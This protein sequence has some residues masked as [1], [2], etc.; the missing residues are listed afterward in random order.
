M[1]LIKKWYYPPNESVLKNAERLETLIKLVNQEKEANGSYEENIITGYS[2]GA[3]CVRLALQKMEKN[4][5]ENNADHHHSK[6]FVSFDGEHG[7]ANVP[8]GLQHLVEHLD[9]YGVFTTNDLLYLLGGLPGAA[10]GA[11]EYYKRTLNAYALHYILNAPLSRELLYYFYTETGTSMAYNLGQGAHPDREYYLQHHDWFDHAKNTHNPGYPSFTRNISIS[12]GTSQS[13]ISGATS[14]HYPF[15]DEGHIIFKQT[16][17]KKS[18]E[19]SFLAPSAGNPWVFKYDEKS[20]GQWDIVEE[21][22]V[23]NPLIL[24]NA[25]GGTTFLAKQ[26]STDGDPNTMYNVLNLMESGITG[27]PDQEPAYNQLYSFT[28]TILTH[29]IRNFQ[30]F[31]PFSNQGRLDYDMKAQ[32]LMYDDI[33]NAI[34]EDPEL[35]SSYFG[36]PHLAHPHDHYTTYTPFDAVFAW[37]NANTVHIGSGEAVWNPSGNDNK[38]RWEEVDSPIGPIIKDFIMEETDY[39]DAYIQNRRYGWNARSDYEYK[40]DII[41]RNII[42]A[43]QE[44]T[45]KTNFNPVILEANAHVKFQA[46]NQI[47]LKPGFTV[48]AGAT[49][50]ASITNIN[51]GCGGTSGMITQP[52]S[53]QGYSSQE[54]NYIEVSE[55]EKNLVNSLV[56]KLYPN[57]GKDVVNLVV[58]D[59]EA[60]GFE[61]KVFSVSGVLVDEN[62]VET[63]IT[64]LFLK[65]GLYIVRLKYKGEW[66]TKKLIMH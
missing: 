46:C 12:N 34:T 11:F 31:T 19:A 29:D 50:E 36:Y 56:V 53:P 59:E 21:A 45:Q 38:G 62:T 32:G 18:W 5:L 64:K 2:A 44:V 3:M 33:N 13:S 27:S 10:V 48:E 37:D 14:D 49:F 51:C 41:A 17:S 63:N 58:E 28:P 4:H 66:Y 16:N 15:P 65:Q 54:M 25:P 26:G 24:D 43:G 8:L 47:V 60:H 42:Y 1:F 55:N 23:H 57:P 6:L 39:F 22:R 52:N 7:G 40:A 30:P 61:Y 20:W 35:A 9:D